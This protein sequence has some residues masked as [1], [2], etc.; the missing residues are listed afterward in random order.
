MNNLSRRSWLVVVGSTLGLMVGVGPII[1]QTVGIFMIPLGEEF[2]WSRTEVSGAKSLGGLFA[3]VAVILVGYGIDRYGLRRVM[4]PLIGLFGLSLMAISQVPNSLVVF[5]VLFIITYCVAA[6]QNVP[7]Y[8][9]A[10]SGWF[11]NRRG[12]AIGLAICGIGLG[13]A[14]VPSYTQFVIDN[15]GWRAAYVALGI[16][17]VAVGIP[18]W[19]FLV[20][21][22]N[23]KERLA[24]E[25]AADERASEVA[26]GSSPA[27]ET[28]PGHTRAEA[29][30]TRQFWILA[31]ST[32][33]ASLAINGAMAHLVPMLRDGGMS[34]AEAAGVLVPV[35]IASLLA[36]P[37]AGLL[38]D[39][40]HGPTVAAIQQVLPIV[41]FVLIASGQF[42]VI[43][44]LLLGLVIGIEV[45]VTS[46]LTTRYFGLAHFGK[47]YGII[48]AVFTVGSAAGALAFASSYDLYGTYTPTFVIVGV[49]LV[50]TA[51]AFLFLGPYTFPVKGRSGRS[52]KLVKTSS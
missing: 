2:G 16:L 20:R 9:K 30:R 50:I 43:G 33:I 13:T 36:R 39:R 15:F 5:Y 24:L 1:L 42:S 27:P 26:D 3:A 52:S 7:P 21:E 38:V 44:A 17:V 29:L 25:V 11:D 46:Y 8:V 51:V 45:D 10:V 12:L 19:L 31:V 28:V 40:F 6:A 23:A 47:I 32:I 34:A 41:S 18:C 37:L 49:G 35:G 48:F 14:V 22:P 4:I